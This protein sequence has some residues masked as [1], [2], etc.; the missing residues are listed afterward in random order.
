MLQPVRT[1]CWA[2]L[3]LALS[4]C[5]TAEQRAARITAEYGPY[6]DKL[7]YP[8]NTDA[9]RNCI[10]AQDAKS[11]AYDRPLKTPGAGEGGFFTPPF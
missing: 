11:R 9:W 4:G 8:R 7:G 10:Q 3:L 6:C 5:V 2:P 1:I